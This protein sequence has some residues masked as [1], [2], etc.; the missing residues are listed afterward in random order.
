MTESSTTRTDDPT[1][2]VGSAD[3][4]TDEQHSCAP[5]SD[6][7]VAVSIDEIER[8]YATRRGLPPR[9]A[10]DGVSLVVPTGQWL[11]LLGPNGSGKS[12]LLRLI[13]T[14]DR[15]TSGRIELFG[16]DALSSTAGQLAAM[17]RRLSV[18]FQ[19]PSLDRLLTV[20]ENL[21][22][23]GGLYAMA[24]DD[25]A[26]AA[27]AMAELLGVASRLDDRVG[28]LS[29]GLARR[30]DIA[31]ALMHRPDLLLLDEASA[32][33]DHRAR[34]DLL[35][36]L[37]Q[38]RTHDG[39][40]LTIVM[41]TH[42]MDEAERA[43]RVVMMH[44]G[45]IVAD[46]SP[47]ELRNAVGGR[48]VRCER[49]DDADRLTALGLTMTLDDRGGAVARVPEND[50]GLIERIVVE[51]ARSGA[52]FEIAPPTLGDAYLQATGE[53]LVPESADGNSP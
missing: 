31:R 15:P 32:G 19:H 30:A 16:D 13:A 17:R 6:A 11:A 35:D 8:V 33:L 26:K 38:L 48:L 4:G 43:D 29:G 2:A 7:S 34:M 1:R 42:L 23:Q 20:R 51:L 5:S 45:R 41:T 21:M 39:R 12:T 3:A 10:V 28:T 46:G 14:L 44:E 24:P 52:A 25:R 9:R 53:Q 22:I 18:V 37:G 49:A 36:L 40:T 27:E 50:K 47:E